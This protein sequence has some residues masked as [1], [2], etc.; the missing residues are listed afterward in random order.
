[1]GN[2]ARLGERV[3]T[4]H[5]FQG[6][7]SIIS[8]LQLSWELEALFSPKWEKGNFNK[9]AWPSEAREKSVFPGAGT[10]GESEM[11]GGE[12]YFLLGSQGHL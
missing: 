2:R 9:R 11:T 5:W 12:W 1:M 8:L 3:P 4:S 10:R 7:V 6:I